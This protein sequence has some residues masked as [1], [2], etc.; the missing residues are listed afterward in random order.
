MIHWRDLR[1]IQRGDTSSGACLDVCDQILAGRVVDV[2]H[3]RHQLVNNTAVAILQRSLL[4]LWRRF[5]HSKHA[6]IGKLYCTDR[7]RCNSDI[8]P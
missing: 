3:N 7:R 6:V 4:V 8:A 5:V 2:R 1:R